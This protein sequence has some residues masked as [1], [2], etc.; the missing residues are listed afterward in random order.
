MFKIVPK[1]TKREDDAPDMLQA[2]L[3]HLKA[4]RSVIPI[5][6][7]VAGGVGCH[8]H[9]KGCKGPGKTPLT[10]WKK[11]QTE[12][13]TEAEV[14]LWFETWP[15]MNIGMATGAVSGTVVLDGDSDAA[16]EF[17][18]S[19][20]EGELA[21]APMV[22]TGK[23]AHWYLEHPGEVVKNFAHK[24]PTLDFRGDGGYVVLPPSLHRSGNRY[25]WHA[26]PEDM[27][28]LAT[29]PPWLMDALRGKKPERQAGKTVTNDECDGPL[30]YR[31]FVDGVPEG[32]RNDRLW[33]LAGSLRARGV[34]IEEARLTMIGAAGR[35]NPP[36]DED[37]ALAMLDRAFETYPAPAPLPYFVDDDEDD[38]GDGAP[39][40]FPVDALPEVVAR[41]VRETADAIVTPP[42]YIAVPLLVSIGAAIGGRLEIAPK[43]GWTEGPN[44]FAACIGKPGSKKSP[45]M[46]AALLP[47]GRLVKL[48]AR[49]HQAAVERW[50]VAHAA[51]KKDKEAVGPEPEKP[52]YPHRW[53][54]D[55]TIEALVPMLEGA[56][57]ILL[58]MDELSAWVASMDQYKN[59]KGADRDHYLS[60]WNRS[61]IK[62]DRRGRIDDPIVVDHPTLSVVGGIQPDRL[63]L[64]ANSAGDDGFLARLLLPWPDPM[65]NGV[66]NEDEASYEATDAVC[67]LFELLDGLRYDPGDYDEEFAYEVRFDAEAKERWLE[68]FAEHGAETDAVADVLNGAWA[69]MPAQLLR[70]TLI[71]HAIAT[72]RS[73]DDADRVRVAGAKRGAAVVDPK[74][75]VGTLDAAITLIEYFKAHA[76][77]VY[78]HLEAQRH[79][80][81]RARD[82][83]SKPRDIRREKVLR[84][85]REEGR[86]AQ[87]KIQREVLQRNVTADE[88][89]HLLAD[90]EAD[91]EIE[92]EHETV[93]ARTIT[94]WK[95]AQRPT[96]EAA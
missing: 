20:G 58:L 4:G 68:W 87:S 39:M 31:Q 38:G 56:P 84:A 95:L 41:Y 22:T 92:R 52:A 49:E 43:R 32:A 55:A 76:R 12:L 85:L 1:S 9:G 33:S 24:W 14:R 61:S 34:D 6:S 80:R 3:D 30:D 83:S 40:P 73:E 7:P 36:Y 46:K 96:A 54:V 25:A 50:K 21:E 62:V 8:Q 19:Q 86:M 93:G 65:P 53:T 78:R 72:V 48:L 94:Y 47:F 2:A 23:G 69:K 64:L 66:I 15:T 71:L 77:R 13:P 79:P 74:V 59:G 91:G 29:V 51:W 57:G 67:E 45:S 26:T 63:S 90:M 17:V 5:C 88:V 11:Y 10:K 37:D 70:M 18:L 81:Q 16:I 42:E 75:S 35:C 44:L 60:L 28:G 82:M 27:G 89:N